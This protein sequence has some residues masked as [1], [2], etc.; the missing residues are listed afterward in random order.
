MLRLFNLIWLILL[1]GDIRDWSPLLG[2]SEAP[3]SV[4]TTKQ[5]QKYIW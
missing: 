4:P 1:V 3:N 5:L 2:P